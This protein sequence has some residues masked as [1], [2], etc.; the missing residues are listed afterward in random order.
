M[1]DK[2]ELIAKEL[3]YGENPHQKAM[4]LATSSKDK[5]AIPNFKII[6]G[7]RLSLN[8]FLDIDSALNVI[9][10]IGKDKPASAIIKHGNPC[11]ASFGKNIEEAF[12]KAWEG[13]SLSAFGGIIIVN[14]EVSERLAKKMIKNF[15][16]ILLAPSISK[17]ALIVFSQKP[18]VAVLLNPALK[19]PFLSKEKDVKNI[20]GGILLQDI[21]QKELKLKDLKF[22]TRKK[23]TKAQIDDLLFAFKVCESSKSNSITIVKNKQVIG[24]GVGATSRVYAAK[25]A[26]GVAGKRASGAVVASDGFFPFT[27]SAILFKKA[28]ICAI[29]QPGGSIADQKV[30]DFCNKN[31]LAMIFTGVRGFKH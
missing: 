2:K 7:N 13:D 10:R 21:S 1:K 4:F 9:S 11:G 22:V 29:I 19:N 25:Q 17:K 6:Q 3:C 28:K 18:K 26:L 15:F 16:E 14:R 8:N 23:P 5:L 31:N 30:I 20:R 27:D 24:N 12:K